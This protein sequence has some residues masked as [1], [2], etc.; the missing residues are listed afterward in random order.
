MFIVIEGLDGTGK[1]T[2]AN[3][4]AKKLGG[5]GLNTPLD[6]FKDVRPKLED[7]K[8]LTKASVVFDR[9]WLSTQVY[10]S[11]RTE[12]IHFKLPKV[13]GMLLKP[14]L[15]VYLELSLEVR[16]KRLGGRD[17]NIEEERQTTDLVANK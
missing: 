7:I 6:K 17:D 1:S 16:I 15:S 4:L 10:H 2:T 5:I 8:E 14:D 9:Y 13:E 11:W 3:A 12:G